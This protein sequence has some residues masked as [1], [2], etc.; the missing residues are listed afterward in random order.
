M[1]G[2]TRRVVGDEDASCGPSLLPVFQDLDPVLRHGTRLTPELVHPLA[3][4]AGGAL[5]ELRRVGKVRVADLVHVESR[6]GQH[7]REM[8][9]GACVVKV[10]VRKVDLPHI[11]VGNA[12][13]LHGGGEPVEAVRR[14]GLDEGGGSTVL[15]EEEE[16][17]YYLPGIHEVKVYYLYLHYGPLGC[18]SK[19]RLYRSS[20]LDL[21]RASKKERTLFWISTSCESYPSR[22][23]RRSSSSSWTAWEGCLCT[24]QARRSSRPRTLRTSTTSPPVLTLD[25]RNLSQRG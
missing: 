7:P 10:Y 2:M 11:F 18:G 8:S 16:R 4:D 3:V 22:L 6:V 19:R 1:V 21:R 13:I 5:Y 24:H 23:T 17:G 9:R 20:L 14:T 12:A 15:A 25:S